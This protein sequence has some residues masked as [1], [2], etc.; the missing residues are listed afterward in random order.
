MARRWVGSVLNRM[1]E[2]VKPAPV[3]VGLGCT[4]LL[5]SDRHAYTVVKVVSPTRAI[6]Q[7]D[8]AFR[9][10]T[11]GMS[12]CQH[13]RFELNP[14]GMEVEIRLCKDGRWHERAGKGWIT[15]TVIAVGRRDEYYDFSF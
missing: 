11:Y 9:T 15:G 5:Y 4:M 13:Y 12:E 1:D 2:N 7:R 10:D 14:A 3:E 8:N 6:I